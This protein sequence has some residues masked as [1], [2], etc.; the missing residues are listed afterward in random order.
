MADD[1]SDWG[2]PMAAGPAPGDWRGEDP[3]GGPVPGGVHGRG[4][5]Q[6]CGDALAGARPSAGLVRALDRVSGP[7]RRCGGLR[8][9]AVF[10][11]LGRWEA[12][13]AWC[14]A[15]KLGVIRALICR[16]A[17]PGYDPAKPGRLP[18]AWREDLAEEVAFELGISG[19]AAGRLVELAWTLEA[20]L[21]LTA[22]ALEAGVISL[23]KARIIAE[24]TAV[25]GDDQ[26]A[27]AEALI[28]GR[29]DGR[30]PTQI[31]QLIA[32][33]VVKVDPDGARKRREQAEKE[34]ARVRLWREH[35]G[36]AALA[37]F[38]LPTDEALAA[39]QNIQGRALEYK[40]WG[41]PGTLDQLRVR[42]FLDIINGTD[43]RAR[44]PKAPPVPD[45]ADRTAAAGPGAAAGEPGSRGGAA[46][47]GTH[48][49]AAGA[50]R[51]G[52]G[53]GP[54]GDAHGG[55]HG[56][57][58]SAGDGDAGVSPAG[59]AANVNLTITLATLLGL[60]DSPGEAEG[61]GALDPA[62]ARRLA[63][64]AAADPRSTW[65]VTVTD[66][67]GVAIGH[68]CA[69]PARTGSRARSGRPGRGG[70]ES[71]AGPAYGF[72][73]EGPPGGYG[74]WQLRVAGI[75]LRV[76]LDPIPV[77]D[78]DHRYE[79]AGYRPSDTLR[80]LVQVR[81]GRCTQPVCVRH[82]RRCDFDHTVPWHKG[83]RSC[84]C[85]G[86]CRCRH[87][88]RLKQTSGWTVSQPLPGWHRWTTPSGKTYMKGP[89]EY[90][91]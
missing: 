67:H 76:R 5:A 20:R 62:L 68:G 31:A 72:A 63:A 61:F 28:A 8:A 45:D 19:Q 91:T 14:A 77:T 15:A 49:D 34:Q 65:C 9:D 74:T 2:V 18:G 38:G 32:R 3:A 10:D 26:A 83:G 37:G 35:A 82:A 4:A 89:K 70:P 75:P 66:C 17:E 40:A 60:A 12:A 7:G 1:T 87:D 13:E 78:C 88:H 52:D 41:V 73:G 85:N 90:P 43:A 50:E 44:Y 22:Q 81:D 47:D 46:A 39:N 30:T 57:P 16:R 59:L 23:T 6:P 86:G 29:L 48:A 84:A 27:A 69:R 64:A 51:D 42:A 54:D 25:L 24:A 11:V 53:H 80:H 33:A 79:S 56:G 58:G 55:R 21:P 71:R 36:T